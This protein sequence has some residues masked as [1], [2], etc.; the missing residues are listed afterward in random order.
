MFYN[1]N[2]HRAK[3]NVQPDTTKD[4]MALA[5]A[6]KIKWVQTRFANYAGKLTSKFSRSQLRQLLLSFCIVSSGF[7]LY[8]LAEGI[9]GSKSPEISF[10]SLRSVRPFDHYQT[11]QNRHAAAYLDSLEKAFIS[12]SIN[13][14]HITR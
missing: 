1:F 9:S 13:S 4:K 10:E 8:M 5:V 11:A 2:A 6:A 3:K 12:D 7:C 14:S